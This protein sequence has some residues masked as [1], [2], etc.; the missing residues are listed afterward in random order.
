MKDPRDEKVLRQAE[1]N[2]RLLQQDLLDLKAFKKEL[3]INE[4]ETR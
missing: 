2:E 1:E 3:G 4:R